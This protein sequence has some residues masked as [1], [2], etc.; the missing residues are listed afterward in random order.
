MMLS[1]MHKP[2]ISGMVPHEVVPRLAHCRRNWFTRPITFVSWMFQVL[3]K[4][5][6]P[7]SDLATLGKGHLERSAVNYESNSI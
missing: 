1:S 7:P 3:E 2:V 5:L 6:V 4:P